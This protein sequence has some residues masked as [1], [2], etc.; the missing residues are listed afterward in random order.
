MRFPPR[1]GKFSWQGEDTC[2]DRKSNFQ[3]VPAVTALFLE[4][5]DG[6]QFSLGNSNETLQGQFSLSLFLILT[7][8]PCSF[9]SHLFHRRGL[10]VGSV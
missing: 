8:P 1:F 2:G 3:D 5:S 10:A 7:S 6:F 9:P 4:Q